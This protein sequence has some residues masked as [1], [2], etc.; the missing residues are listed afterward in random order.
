M[1]HEVTENC[2]HFEFFSC[3]SL[4]KAVDNDAG[5]CPKYC[6][7]CPGWIL[8]LMTKAGVF[9]VY[10]LIDRKQPRCEMFVYLTKTEAE[11]KYR[12]L[13]GKYSADVLLT[14]YEQEKAQ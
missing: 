12:E 11:E 6:N 4:S 14:N 9:S 3:P 8:P 2:Y 10:N 5:P 1:A 13:T 7:H